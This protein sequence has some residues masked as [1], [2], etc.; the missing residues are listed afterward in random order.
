MLK[1]LLIK[2]YA[3]IR[4]LEIDPT[5]DLNIITGETG[6]GKSIMIGAAG[7]L[8]GNRADGRVLYDPEEKC[9]IEGTFILKNYHLQEFFISNNLDY[10]DETVIRREIAPG[11][12]SRAFVNDT[13]VNLDLMR[14][15]GMS[16]MEIH[17]QTDT[18]KLGSNEFQLYLIDAYAQ[19]QNRL[20][21]YRQCYDRYLTAL[22]ELRLLQEEAERI[23]K[24]AD[25]NHF[26]FEELSK[27][28]LTEGEQ[29]GL[30]EEVHSLEHAEE[31]K[32]KLLEAADIL[33]NRE[34]SVNESLGTVN[35]NLEQ[36]SA[37][38]RHLEDLRNRVNSSWLE[39][40]DIAGE[41][42]RQADKVE[43][44]PSRLA[45]AGERLNLIYRLQQKHQ[46]DS[47]ATLIR[48]RDEL[49]GK[50]K[51][52]LNLDEELGQLIE[53]TGTLLEEV[54]ASGR[55]LSGRRKKSFKPFVE[56]LETLL[57]ELGIPD[58]RLAIDLAETDPGPGGID[59]I[60][61]RFSANKGIPP[62]PFREVASGGEFSRL[63]FCIKSTIARSTA[64]PT[65]V[66]DE[67]DTGISGEIAIKMARLMKNM[68][69]HHQVIAITHL[70]QIA[71]A[72]SSHYYVYK[73]SSDRKSV[74]L[75]RKLEKDE[76]IIEIAK[77]ISGD[78]PSTAAVDSARELL[79]KNN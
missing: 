42:A 52:N 74:S 48:I 7:L 16:L 20:E 29:E 32:S 5:P 12:K 18:M 26:L 60:T 27:A 14:Q 58:A 54:K 2:N 15:L 41:I 71:A 24:D 9:I 40:R 8:L 70:P 33:M 55:E 45:A 46:A 69:D 43:A 77:M 44:D 51:K 39:I 23:R 25:Y 79:V 57:K 66:L 63:M 73:D 72:G 6:A 10:Q 13:P 49:E 21:Q 30:E 76:R 38:T 17:S 65:L 78:K 67:I 3:L 50:V 34:L 75:I 19:N 1:S 4:N 56:E 36:I 47:I 59:A 62:K 53:K 11:G 61:L 22:K 28:S 64:L 68:S 37:Y 35:K 31:I